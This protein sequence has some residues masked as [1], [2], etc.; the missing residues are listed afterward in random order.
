MKSVNRLNKKSFLT[1]SIICINKKK[2]KKQAGFHTNQF[3]YFFQVFILSP[4]LLQ[5]TLN[6]TKCECLNVKYGLTEKEQ[7]QFKWNLNPAAT[8]SGIDV[9]LN[10]VKRQ[11]SANADSFIKSLTVLFYVI[12]LMEQCLNQSLGKTLIS[13]D[14]ES[15]CSRRLKHG[16]AC[17]LKMNNVQKRLAGLKIAT[18]IQKSHSKSNQCPGA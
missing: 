2:K 6:N 3:H 9:F 12:S 8:C 18:F 14:C 5:P 4:T 13:S 17:L 15:Y 7:V 16:S 1:A 10:E 11:Q